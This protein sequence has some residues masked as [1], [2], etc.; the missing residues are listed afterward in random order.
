M[1]VAGFEP[2]KPKGDRFTVYYNSPSL[3]HSQILQPLK[4][5]NPYWPR[6][7]I[8]RATLTLRGYLFVNQ[9]CQRT[10]CNLNLQLNNRTL[11]I[12]VQENL[13]YF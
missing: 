7:K 1:G 3:P 13:F 4:D 5:S 10:I 11:F 9:K 12:K 8:S 6:T 2:A